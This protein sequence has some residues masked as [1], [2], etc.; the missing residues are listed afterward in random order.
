MLFW[1]SI[2]LSPMT[3][4]FKAEAN[5]YKIKKCNKN[6]LNSLQVDRSSASSHPFTILYSPVIAL[7]A[8]C[9][10]PCFIK[11]HKNTLNTHLVVPGIRYVSLW[12]SL[13]L[14]K[15]QKVRPSQLLALKP[16]SH[17]LA[18]DSSTWE[19]R[20]VT[21]GTRGEEPRATGKHLKV[22]PKVTQS[23]YF[24]AVSFTFMP[25]TSKIINIV[26]KVKS[27]ISAYYLIISCYWKLIIV[28]IAIAI[29]TT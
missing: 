19:K 20:A 5:S 26:W 22:T 3:F 12:S 29:I 1:H 25:K 6:Y 27:R 8:A 18:T 10:N 15:H 13:Q 4:V 28:N 24:S 9:F 23:L 7:H 2:S 11:G 21:A 14:R 17:V 16:R